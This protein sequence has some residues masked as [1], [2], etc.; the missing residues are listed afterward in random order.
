MADGGE[1]LVTDEIVDALADST[2]F[3]FD[4]DDR[5]ELKGLPGDHRLWTV[6]AAA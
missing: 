4:E 5:V 2:D 3:R 1:I 6:E